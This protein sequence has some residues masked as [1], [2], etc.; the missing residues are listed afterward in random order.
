VLAPVAADVDRPPRLGQ[1]LIAAVALDAERGDAGDAAAPVGAQGRLQATLERAEVAEVVGRPQADAER[2]AAVEEGS[3]SAKSSRNMCGWRMSSGWSAALPCGTVIWSC[4]E[5]M[6]SAASSSSSG[7]SSLRV[8]WLICVLQAI[9]PPA[10][11]TSTQRREGAPPAAG[12]AAEA[13]W[14][15]SRPSIETVTL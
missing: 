3:S 9:L 5:C 10:A 7:S 8:R 15:A 14:V 11:R 6:P 2:L 1:F 12:H 4:H 13:S